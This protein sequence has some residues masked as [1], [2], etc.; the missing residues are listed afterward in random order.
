MVQSPLEE[1]L[2]QHYEIDATQGDW[3]LSTMDILEQ[4]DTLG[5]RGDQYRNKLELTTVLTK[6][7]LKKERRR[8]EGGQS[9]GYIGIRF[10]TGALSVSRGLD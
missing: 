8:I 2:L 9:R 1:L 4:L 7:G 5:L 6:F 10:K 3:Y